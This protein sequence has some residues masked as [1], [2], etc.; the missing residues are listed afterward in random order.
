MLWK[1]VLFVEYT[2]CL[3][4]LVLELIEII[5]AGLFVAMI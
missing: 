4:C 2:S 1:H 3:Q 5:S